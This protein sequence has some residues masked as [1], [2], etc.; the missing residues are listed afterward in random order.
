MYFL[1]VCFIT[2][3]PNPCHSTYP[4]KDP[5][6]VRSVFLLTDGCANVGEKD[7]SEKHIVINDCLTA[8]LI[9][10]VTPLRTFLEIQV[11]RKHQILWI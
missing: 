7:Q 3:K 1:V 5:N 8:I 4:L 6:K 11:I 9:L 2:L 10:P